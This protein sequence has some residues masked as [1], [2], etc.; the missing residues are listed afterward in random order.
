MTKRPTRD[1]ID[2][3]TQVKENEDSLC[4]PYKLRYA[5]E[6]RNDLRAMGYSD[7]DIDEI[8]EKYS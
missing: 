6:L 3:C 1:V 5:A 2:W 8:G 4:N 7:R